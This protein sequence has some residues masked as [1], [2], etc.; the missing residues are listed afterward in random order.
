MT[1]VRLPRS[2]SNLVIMGARQTIAWVLRGQWTALPATP[3]P[4]QVGAELWD[5]ELRAAV[6]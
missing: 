4:S 1:E 6:S 5:G 2:E 3:K